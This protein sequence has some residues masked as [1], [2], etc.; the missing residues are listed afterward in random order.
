[1]GFEWESYLVSDE[2]DLIRIG[3]ELFKDVYGNLRVPSL[4]IVPKEEPWPKDVW[5]LRLGKSVRQIRQTG[6][7]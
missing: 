3:L 1:M 5:G 4:F 7:W 6:E 2:W